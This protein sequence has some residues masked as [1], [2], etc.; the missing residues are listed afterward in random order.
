MTQLTIRPR[1]TCPRAQVEAALHQIALVGADS[2]SD[3]YAFPHHRGRTGTR[4]MQ[5]LGISFYTYSAMHWMNL[6]RGRWNTAEAKRRA[7]LMLVDPSAPWRVVVMLGT[8]VRAAFRA[9]CKAFYYEDAAGTEE[10]MHGPV[11]LVALP[12]PSGNR[13]WNDPA[14]KIDVVD[15]MRAVAPD[16]PWGELHHE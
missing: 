2:E 5:L 10:W 14:R 13:I 15:V 8:K 6:C 7:N 3:V 12:H 16:V 4:L 11:K 1:T 9:K